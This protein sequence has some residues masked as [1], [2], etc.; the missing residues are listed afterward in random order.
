MDFLTKIVKVAHDI[1]DYYGKWSRLID[2]Y[3]ILASSGQNEKIVVSVL[4]CAI[5]LLVL[6]NTITDWRRQRNGKSVEQ[7]VIM[8]ED[9][10]EGGSIE[11]VEVCGEQDDSC[12]PSEN[13]MAKLL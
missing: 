9:D 5:S 10:G 6:Y 12:E 8:K 4:V 11:L 13:G 1:F 2:I 3:K 7:T